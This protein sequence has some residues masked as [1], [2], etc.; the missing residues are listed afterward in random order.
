MSPAPHSSK[1][2]SWFAPW[3]TG[4]G[5]YLSQPGGLTVDCP[6]VHGPG[7]HRVNVSCTAPPAF[8]CWGQQ[9]GEHLLQCALNDRKQTCLDPTAAHDLQCALW[10]SVQAENSEQMQYSLHKHVRQQAISLSAP[11]DFFSSPML[12]LLHLHLALSFP[13]CHCQPLAKGRQHR[14]TVQIAASAPL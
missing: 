10:T 8:S 7:G 5:V 1:L 11:P 12:P 6:A 4:L 14:V 2:P 9:M 3:Q 13:A